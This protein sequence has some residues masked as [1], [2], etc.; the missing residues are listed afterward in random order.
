MDAKFKECQ[1]LSKSSETS[2]V[3]LNT[4][5]LNTVDLNTVDFN[6]VDDTWTGV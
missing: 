3:D 5:D 6:I 4:V 2:I 1:T